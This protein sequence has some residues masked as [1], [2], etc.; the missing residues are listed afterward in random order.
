ML[1]LRNSNSVAAKQIFYLGGPEIT[2][3]DPDYFR[4]R[5]A[6]LD[7]LNEVH[8]G[9]YDGESILTR[10][11]PDDGIRRELRKAGIQDVREFRKQIRKPPH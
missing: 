4:R 9:S 1:E 6:L 5:P 3:L 2:L 7:K 8:I 10:V 11:I